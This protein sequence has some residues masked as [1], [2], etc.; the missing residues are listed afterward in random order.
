MNTKNQ[1]KKI[2][3][4]SLIIIS[5]FLVSL[6]GFTIFAIAIILAPNPEMY[7]VIAFTIVFLIRS[8]FIQG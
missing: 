7:S 1:E 5:I 3:Y 8:Y 6:V 2:L 4:I